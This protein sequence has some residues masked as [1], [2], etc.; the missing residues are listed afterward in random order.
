[1]VVVKTKYT[2]KLLS[3]FVHF[4]LKKSWL[5]I[6]IYILAV[7]SLGGGL[8]LYLLNKQV[9][10]IVALIL[11]GIF[12]LNGLFYVLINRFSNRRAIGSTETIVFDEDHLEVTVQ[13][14]HGV[15]IAKNSCIY[16][17]LRAVKKYKNYGYIYQNKAV[18]YIVE[19]ESFESVDQFNETLDNLQNFIKKNK[20]RKEPNAL[21]LGTA[22]VTPPSKDIVTGT[23]EP[24][25]PPEVIEEVERERGIK[26]SQPEN[27]D[28]QNINN[29]NQE[30]NNETESE[31]P[32]NNTEENF[33]EFNNTTAKEEN[34]SAEDDEIA[35]TNNANETENN[36]T[37]SNA[38]SEEPNDFKEDEFTDLD[39]A[40]NYEENNSNY[41]DLNNNTNN[42][43]DTSINTISNDDNNDNNDN[44]NDNASI[45]DGGKILTNYETSKEENLENNA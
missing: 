43:V 45:N 37:N 26:I 22:N 21:V 16:A 9:E 31:E 23:G 15:E 19:Q 25:P 17:C 20:L 33:E 35:D 44:S 7:I 36:E 42:F 8:A 1:M 13:D 18:A 38:L 3:T 12:L 24:T 27:E 10:G 2:K 41:N 28:N 39:N 32:L 30:L 11:G 5:M 14:K 40:N 6:F 29:N 4:N 34:T